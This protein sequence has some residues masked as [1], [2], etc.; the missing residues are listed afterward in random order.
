M[1][2]RYFLAPYVMLDTNC[3]I[4]EAMDKSAT[5]SKPYSRAIW[6]V[7]GVMLLIG[8][9][10]VIPYIGWM[11]AFVLGMLYSVAPALRYQELKKINNSNI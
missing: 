5:M 2:R 10:N 6:G 8:F 9:I 4:K 1:L 3:G 7:I 11:V